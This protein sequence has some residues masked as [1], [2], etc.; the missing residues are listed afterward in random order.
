MFPATKVLP[1]RAPARLVDRPR[2][3]CLA[4]EAE[5]KRL[6]VIKAPAGF[7]KT[8]LALA[9][10]ERLRM[11]NAQVAWLSLDSDDD[12]P[13]RFLNHLAHAL[14]HACSGVGASAIGLTAQASLVPAQTVLSTLINEL[15]DVGDE[16]YLFLDDY[17]VISLSAVHD[18]LS[19]FVENAP[20]NVHVVICTRTAP[21]LPLARL[22]AYN[23]ILEIEAPMLRFT[24]DETQRFVE[25]E[26]PG[27]L[28]AADVKSLLASTEGWA[29]ALRIST[30]ALSRE[31]F[32]PG[33]EFIA[34]SGASRHFAAYLEDMLERL[35]AE[36]V[37][38]MLRT[39]IL[40]RLTASLC[41]A[42]TGVAA[43]QRT[44]EDVAAHQLLLEPID[45]EGHWFRYHHLMREYLRQ[46]LE[47]QYPVEVAELHRRACAWYTDHELWTDAVRH[48]IASGA[49]EDALALMGHCAMALVRNGDLLTLLGWQRHFPVQLMRAQT[50][51][52]L[53]IAWGMAL[54]MR[55]EEALLMLKEVEHDAQDG[56]ADSGAI[57]LECQAIRSVV[58]A[59]QDDALKALVLAQGCL[60]QPST[61][62]W[63]TN[64][65]SNVVR[66]GQWK[67][68]NLEA[69]YATPWIPYSIDED[70]RNMFSSVYRL[71][72]LGHAEMQQ[73]HFPL[74]E[75]YF[76]DSMQ[77]AERYA[78]PQSTSAAL[79]APMI[80]QIRYEQGRLDEAEALL[81]D[82]MPV[83]D[84]AAFLD[85]VLIAYR[86]LVRIAVDRSN[87]GQAY[88]LLDRAY[89]LGHARGWDR[90]KAAALVERTRLYLA[91][92][93][94]TEASVCASQLHQLAASV[95][96]RTQLV[97]P[98]IETYRAIA[99]AR[100]SIA[101]KRTE[102]AVGLL[103]TALRSV[104]NRRNDYLA[105]HLRIE[106]SLVA[107][108]TGKRNLAIAAFRGV[109]T[110]AAS[111]GIF[112]SILDQGPEI[113]PL[114]LA[115]REE[116]PS[117]ASTADAAPYIHALLD[118]WR[119]RYEPESKPHRDAQRDSLSPRERSIVALIAQ[120]QSNK[121]IART[122]GIT[123][124]TVK[125]YLKNI[126]VKLGVEK[127]A[128]AVARA[129]ELG[130]MEGISTSRMG[131][132]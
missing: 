89:A 82:L 115:L 23:E 56:C 63:T 111:A 117:P 41:E 22:R 74:A 47:R 13:A 3:I 85:C 127:R 109:V 108:A 12:E 5:N 38:F 25:S 97:S 60:A 48:A 59:L 44:L 2:L 35:P 104:E 24:F 70:Q 78:G 125:S 87:P 40:D 84:A 8:S 116:G 88:A 132:T 126:F 53:A 18:A 90:L 79:C 102:D 95:G 54:A 118:G 83:I 55:F 103:N 64:V 72:L 120:G 39:S 19:F 99:A 68:G 29:A 67:A 49:T 119:A 71:C 73:M 45:L 11:G 21:A 15:V 17:H 121:E 20:A 30:S 62:V 113:G 42:V 92:G 76:L 91:E 4:D 77:L 86:V 80:S 37:A 105:L 36:T 32:K 27:K 112:R 114:L 7:G 101:Q 124:E 28:A 26:C 16:V 50:R 130:L 81:V 57:L 58:A 14:R 34:P 106:L 9:W 31:T 110:T 65:V 123:P 51:V 131:A 46:R 100:L 128:Q 1:P 33:R 93:R 98:E 129:Q 52:S 122:I 61:D 6:V 96:E 69:L 10:F 66:F 43:S 75:R 107:M 94:I